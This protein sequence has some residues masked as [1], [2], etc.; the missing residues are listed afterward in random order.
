[1]ESGSYAVVTLFFAVPQVAA[2]SYSSSKRLKRLAL[3][4]IIR[5]SPLPIRKFTLLITLF[6]PRG[7]SDALFV[8][9][10]TS[11]TRYPTHQPQLRHLLGTRR[12][13]VMNPQLPSLSWPQASFDIDQVHDAQPNASFYV[14]RLLAYHGED[15]DQQFRLE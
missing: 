9:R 12:G 6:L 1:M 11:S 8:C 7:A 13:A 15:I 3:R 5:R 4:K 2:K 10:E 14:I